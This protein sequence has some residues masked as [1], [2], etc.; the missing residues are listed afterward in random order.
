MT[1][2]TMTGAIVHPYLFILPVLRTAR[3]SLTAV[4]TTIGQL[5]IT[6]FTFVVSNLTRIHHLLTPIV[7][8]VIDVLLQLIVKHLL[9]FEH[10]IFENSAQ[11]HTFEFVNP[12]GALV[13]LHVISFGSP[14]P[15]PTPASLPITYPLIV[16]PPLPKALELGQLR[17]FS[18]N[19]QSNRTLTLLS[20][21]IEYGT[22]AFSRRFELKEIFEVLS[23]PHISRVE[24][25]PLDDHDGFETSDVT[26]M[27]IVA[28]PQYIL[29]TV[30]HNGCVTEPR[31]VSKIAN[32]FIVAKSK[33][34]Q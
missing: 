5:T 12:S 7:I 4:A 14:P 21:A 15:V 24:V 3:I 8:D 18:L 30:A 28:N 33:M 2:L 34:N 22:A 25:I 17:A 26:L 31:T 11:R 1:S 16:D 6:G 23:V 29:V 13:S 27:V 19:C 32:S 20:C 9:Q 10:R